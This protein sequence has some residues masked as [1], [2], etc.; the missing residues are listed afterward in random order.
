MPL[1]LWA[2]E[3]GSM[4]LLAIQALVFAENSAANMPGEYTFQVSSP[5]K[6]PPLKPGRLS[7]EADRLSKEDPVGRFFIVFRV[8]LDGRQATTTRVEME[9]TWSGTL[10][11]AINAH[12][13][14]AVISEDDFLMIRFEGVPPS[15]AVKAL[16]DNVRLRQPLN[17]GKILTHMDI[18]PVPLVNATDRVRVTLQ[19]G[20]LQII[21]VATARSNAAKGGRVRLEMDGS[22]KIVQGIVIGP[23]EAVIDAKS[24]GYRQ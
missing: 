4:E 1:A 2:Q 16:P 24:S 10:Y 12:Q 8:F 19:N 11:Q 14:K 3:A 17:I 22:K 23:C 21:S 15:G 5:P 18:E 6:L 20:P 9:G 7:F 13:R